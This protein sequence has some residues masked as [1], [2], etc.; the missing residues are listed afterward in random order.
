M[1]LFGGPSVKPCSGFDFLGVVLH[2][3]WSKMP[4][5]WQ[6]V[7]GESIGGLAGFTVLLPGLV[8]SLGE[9][10]PTERSPR[11]D[12]WEDPSQTMYMA[13]IGVLCINSPIYRLFRAILALYRPN[14]AYLWLYWP[15]Y[16]K[17]TPFWLVHEKGPFLGSLS[18][19]HPKRVLFDE[20]AKKGWF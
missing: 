18:I 15:I 13:Y 14:I 5:K 10:F 9:G 20:L 17:T 8:G 4:K 2:A 11:E 7:E 12:P 3:K 6:N 1:V 16:P 19:N